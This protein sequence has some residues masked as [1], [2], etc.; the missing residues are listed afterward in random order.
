MCQDFKTKLILLPLQKYRIDALLSQLLAA[1]Y[2]WHATLAHM[3]ASF[4]E[5]I[6]FCI[7]DWLYLLL[8]IFEYIDFWMERS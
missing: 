4:C 3:L 1:L 7:V 8:Y 2:K 6:N 5:Y